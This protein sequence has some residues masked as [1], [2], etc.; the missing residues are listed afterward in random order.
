MLGCAPS[1]LARPK[2]PP[3][4]LRQPRDSLWVR[5]DPRRAAEMSLIASTRAT[6]LNGRRHAV[7]PQR[8]AHLCV[9]RPFPP[10]PGDGCPSAAPGPR[11]W[12]P[13]AN[14][15]EQPV[16]VTANSVPFSQRHDGEL[17]SLSEVSEILKTPVRYRAF[18]TIAAGTGMRRGEI[19]GLTLERIDFDFGTIRIDRQLARSAGWTTRCGVRRRPSRRPGRFRWPMW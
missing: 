14:Q 3:A 13:T 12:G 17:L 1:P 19:L 9:R 11:S 2:R 10:I 6:D 4:W 8:A 18:A 15:P 5:P 7:R 16:T